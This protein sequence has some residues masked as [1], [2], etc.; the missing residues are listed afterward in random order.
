M[1]KKSQLTCSQY[2]EDIVFERLMDPCG[3]GTYVDVGAHHPIDGSNTYKLYARGWRGLTVDPNPRF[4]RLFRRKRPGDVHLVEG[5][6]SK[7]GRLVYYQFQQDVLNTFSPSRAADLVAA[8]HAVIKESVVPCRPLAKMIDEH[9]GDTQI[10]LLNVDCE[11]SDMDVL[12][13]LDPSLRR[14]TVLMVEDYDRMKSFQYGQKPGELQNFLRDLGYTPIAQAGWTTIL[15]ANN[16]QELF[17]RSQ[18][19]C[20]DRVQNGYLPGQ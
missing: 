20:I 19:Y 16:W 5:A 8:G 9:L 18:A 7:S 15:V 14:P 1:L 3:K 2:A 13:S 17:G 11:A 6:S 10:D 12:I 4:A